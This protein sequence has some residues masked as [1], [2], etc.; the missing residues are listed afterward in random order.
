MHHRWGQAAAK[1]PQECGHFEQRTS[2]KKSS[3]NL[4][5]WFER[6]QSGVAFSKFSEPK[7]FVWL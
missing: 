5:C 2:S 7:R 3:V 6:Q 4:K 1:K